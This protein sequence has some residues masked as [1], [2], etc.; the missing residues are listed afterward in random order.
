MRFELVWF[1]R[2]TQVEFCPSWEAG[3]RIEFATEV[4]SRQAPFRQASAASRAESLVFTEFLA[5][6]GTKFTFAAQTGGKV[7]PTGE[8]RHLASLDRVGDC[9]ASTISSGISPGDATPGA[10]SERRMRKIVAPWSIRAR[11]YI[12]TQI[13]EFGFARSR[14]QLSRYGNYEPSVHLHD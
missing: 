10:Y 3:S 5:T 14:T 2:E 8:P 6:K 7:R 11:C 4:I 12:Q 1:R 9:S 13:G